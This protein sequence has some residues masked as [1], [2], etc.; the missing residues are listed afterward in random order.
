MPAARKLFVCSVPAVK[1]KTRILIAELFRRKPER[2]IGWGKA[3]PFELEESAP[4]PAEERI[5]IHRDVRQRHCNLHEAP[6]LQTK[7]SVP[8]NAVNPRRPDIVVA[9]KL[10][11]PE[12]GTDGEPICVHMEAKTSMNQFRKLFVVPI[13]KLI[14]VF[15]RTFVPSK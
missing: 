2:D 8:N 15:A 7:T 9:Q 14:N 1:A 13:I 12:I 6:G 10:V 4:M 11:R 5:R 3:D